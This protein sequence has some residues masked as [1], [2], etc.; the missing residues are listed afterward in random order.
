MSAVH[1]AVVSMRPAVTTARAT[2][3]H[4]AAA[5]PSATVHVLDVDGSYRPFGAETVPAP[6]QVGLPATRLHRM[7]AAREH[8]ALETALYPAL[9]RTLASQH[10]AGQVVLALRPA[11]PLQS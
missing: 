2:V 9:L 3:A 7:A 6:D 8:R 4:A 1:I 11:G 10:D 5:M